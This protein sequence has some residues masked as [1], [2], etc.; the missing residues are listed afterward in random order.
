MGKPNRR[1]LTAVKGGGGIW[2]F[3][4]T[5][6]GVENLLRGCATESVKDVLTEPQA[7]GDHC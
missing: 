4:E 6:K 1:R 5:R 7:R 3:E 2:G